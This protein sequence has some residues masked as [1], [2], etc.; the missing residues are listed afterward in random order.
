M[1]QGVKVLYV[2]Y[3]ENFDGIFD[4]DK[5]WVEIKCQ[6]NIEIEDVVWDKESCFLQIVLVELVEFNS[7]VIII[8]FNVINFSFGIYYM[9]V[10]V[11]VFGDIFV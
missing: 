1:I 10:D 8:F 5:V 3:F 7:Q 11:M 9:V 4:V 2:F 6:G